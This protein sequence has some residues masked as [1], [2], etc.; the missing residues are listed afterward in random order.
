LSK[1]D[2]RID[3]ILDRIILNVKAL[4]LLQGSEG[5]LKK[6]LRREMIESHDDQVRRFVDSLQSKRKPETAKFLV[7]ALGELILSSLLVLAGTLT[8]IPVMVGITTP[9]GLVT[10]F[11]GQFYN[12]LANSPFRP[13][14][15]LIEFAAGALLILSAFYTLRQAALSLKEMGLA[16]KKGEH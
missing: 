10:Y 2:E 13:Y 9:Q 4:V 16:V 3:E 5:E 1:S 7:I 14:T 6:K 11:S 15:G 8:I 12:S